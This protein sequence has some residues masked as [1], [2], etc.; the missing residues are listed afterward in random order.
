MA[1]DTAATVAETMV[2]HI[3]IVIIVIF[4][5]YMLIRGCPFHPVRLA[6]L[7]TMDIMTRQ[8][9]NDLNHLHPVDTAP[10]TLIHTIPVLQIV[11]DILKQ[12]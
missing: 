8:L 11:Q 9:I 7:Q 5:V 6:I 1:L 12:M 2:H 4:T 3:T 10:H